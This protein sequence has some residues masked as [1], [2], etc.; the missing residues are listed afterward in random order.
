MRSTVPAR[1]APAAFLAF[2][3]AIPWALSGCDNPACVFGGDCSPGGSGGAV[4]T[5]AANVPEDGQ[6][7]RA[8]IPRIERFAPQG[9]EVDP[10]SPIVIVF[11]ESMSPATL[12]FAFELQQT[13]FGSIPLQASALVG[14]GRVL[15]M[16]PLTDLMPSGQYTVR[17]RN[18]VH[19]GDRTGQEVVQPEDQVVG[20]FTV[21]ATAPTLPEVILS[22]PFD[23]E[24]GLPATT[25]ITVVFSRPMDAGTVDDSSFQVEVAGVA[26][27]FDPPPQPVTISGLA[28][29]TRV[30]RWRSIDDQGQRASLGTDQPVAVELSPTAARILDTDGNQLGLHTFSFRTMAFSAPLAATITS[31]PAD[32]IG[33]NAITGPADLAIQVD[34]EDALAGDELG[35]FIFGIQPENVQAP[36]LV[37]LF[38]SAI[39]VDPP[40]SFTFTAAELNLVLNA[41]P[42]AARVRDGTIALAFRVKRGDVESPVRLLDVDP[43]AAGPQGPFLDT[44][45]PV[46]YGLGTTGTSVGT[47]AS[48]LRDVVLV[49]RA[50]EALR[51]VYV[52]TPL[53]DNE[54]TPGEVPPVVG[55]DAESGIF[56]AGPV[57]VDI[58]TPLDQPLSYSL[59]IYDRALNSGG[60]ATGSFS[61]RGAASNGFPRPFM[62]VMVEVFD[63][64]TLAPIEDAE[65]LS[66]EDDFGS[67]FLLG[68][69]PTG[70]DGR[71]TVDPALVGRTVVTVRK[72]GYDLFTFDGVPTDQV[73]IPLQPSAQ[74]GASVAGTVTSIDPSVNAYTRRVGDTRFP[75]PGETLAA[76]SSC[77]FDTNDQ[78]FE[79]TFGPAQVRSRELGA[80]TGMAVLPPSSALLWTAPSFLRSFGM[81]LPLADLGPGVPQANLIVALDRLDVPGI[82]EELQAVDA[83]PHVLT[84]IAW[85]DLNGD[86]RIRVEGL[87]PG[88]R[89]P[90][91]VGQGLA[92]GAGLPP[93]TYAVRAA[94]RAWP[95]RSRTRR[96]TCWDVS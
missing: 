42:L 17:F 64:T 49:G 62:Q 71:A 34:L 94:Y 6:I 43:L 10:K 48:D 35:V 36:L 57:P 65:V 96:A 86:P 29:D 37:A 19:V 7:V 67:L 14:D 25:E 5:L 38:R 66:H 9:A 76:V 95:T 58:L 85:P 93:S 30:F 70:P 47:F 11:S 74:A 72:T 26:P 2:V 88:L 78:R 51:G 16:F 31:F 61:Q 3:L 63:A 20:S 87:V 54:V 89:G 68:S 50:S 92:F 60:T 77:S 40:S 32:A 33:I 23:T 82:D 15:V 8:L 22:Y 21:A 4:G 52:T 18:N 59:T 12:G 56:I 28:T 55:S 39:V 24:T 41:S 13:G 90:L 46:L 91:T 53:G 75:R 80:I 83:P 69:W 73:S 1:R 44:T 79:C 27:P 81:R 45:A 84:T